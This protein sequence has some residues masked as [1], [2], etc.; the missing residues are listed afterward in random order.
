M[1]GEII[2]GRVAEY[3]KA[4]AR[5]IVPRG[6]LYPAG[7]EDDPELVRR[8]DSFVSSLD[9]LSRKGVKV[10]FYH[11][12]YMAAVNTIITVGAYLLC[13]WFL[14]ASGA[15]PVIWTI[16]YIMVT[17]LLVWGEIFQGL[18]FGLEPLHKMDDDKA[19][20][21]VESLE[22]SRISFKRNLFMAL[23]GFVCMGFY[24]SEEYE[25]FIGYYD[26]HLECMPEETQ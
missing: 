20:A 24:S 10:A 8:I 23:K 26:Y 11:L 6:G 1:E 21:F 3:F 16:V 5:Q 17:A 14:R 2:T 13:G 15:G 22:K 25:K 4:F 12:N 9:A 19:H 18:H 7:A